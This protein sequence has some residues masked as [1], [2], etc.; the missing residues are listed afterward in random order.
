MRSLSARLLLSLLV[1]LLL[2]FGVTIAALD[3]VFRDLSERS[4]RELLDVQVLTLISASDVDAAGGIAPPVALLD[5]RYSN[6]G[7]GLY[8]E[9]RDSTGATMWRSPSMT[10]A[11]VAFG[12]PLPQG[13][14]RYDTIRTTGGD[15]LV[16]LSA[17][18]HWEVDPHTAR[19]YV[20]SVAASLAPAR[21]QLARF[22]TQLLL[23]FGGLAAVLLVA[24]A[25][26]LRRVLAP[27]RRITR[28]VG[29]VQ[30]GQAVE[31]GDGYP[32]ELAGVTQAVNALMNSER[33]RLERY[34]NTLGNLAHSLK[35]PIA[36]MRS[37]L[38]EKHDSSGS[39]RIVVEQVKRMDDIVQHQLRRA[40]ASGGATLGQTAIPA[41]PVFTEL[42][43]ALLRAYAAKDLSILIECEAG[44]QFIGE[45]GDLLEL[46]GNI[47]D[48]AC[49][50]CKTT[51]RIR[52]QVHGT[53]RP[54]RITIEDDGA[55][56]PDAA[57]T[58]IFERGVRVDESTS[59]Q[60]L[61]LSMAR[62]IVEQYRGRLAVGESEL[63]GTQIELALP[64]NRAS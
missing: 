33:L 55:G 27:L 11:G 51:V 1:L 31:L 53:D 17:G 62:D 36:V 19:D 57:R 49:K 28:E 20:F 44:V 14:R 5:S 15:A 23:W 43:V 12:P 47:A 2:F 10:G 3:S 26:L 22:R 29:A 39:D 58:R 41:L 48:N 18:F 34:R 50:Y 61:G 56:I 63:G 35:T 30:A 60:G 9:I 16:S 46:L 52:A 4:L 38:G 37:V 59:G 21:A 45:R 24:V 42:R 32:T 54:L 64:G 8:G 40:T 7:S 25:L 13:Q 6:P